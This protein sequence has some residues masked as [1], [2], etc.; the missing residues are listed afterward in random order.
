MTDANEIIHKID[1]F[2]DKFSLKTNKL[3]DQDLIDFIENEWKKADNK[4]Y[5][6]HQGVII[7]GRMINEYTRRKDFENMMRWLEMSN[8]HTSS[9][10]HPNYIINYYNGQCCLECGNEKKALEYFNLCYNENPDYIYSRAPFCYEFF[11]KH[12]ES[13]RELLKQEDEDESLEIDLTLTY[14]QT[15][16]KEN[17]DIS[18]E[19]FDKDYEEITELT[20]KHKE[21]LVYIEENQE[22]I[23][24][25][26]LK[27][28]LNI[29]PTLQKRYNYSEVDKPDFMPDLNSIEGFSSLLSPHTIYILEKEGELPYIGFLLGCSWDSEHGLGIMTYK[30]QVEDIGGAETAF[31][32]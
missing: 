4:K 6:I 19:I 2:L 5:D 32:I 7:M 23:L 9:Q 13:P 31:S 21:Y 15:F 12:R 28:L 18:C 20:N 3:T 11:N 10:K 24:T 8:L 17:D 16:F 22:E 25:N 29:Y 30:K 1:K 26:I 14:W 27:E